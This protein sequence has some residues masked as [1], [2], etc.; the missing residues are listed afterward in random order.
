M[1][2]LRS[3]VRLCRRIKGAIEATF[4]RAAAMLMAAR[5]LLITMSIASFQQLTPAESGVGPTI[6]SSPTGDLV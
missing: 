5:A 6:D 2:L 1:R 4:S 3:R